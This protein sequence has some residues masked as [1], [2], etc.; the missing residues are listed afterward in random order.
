M[1]RTDKHTKNRL[2]RNI[3]VSLHSIA[4]QLIMLGVLW[5]ALPV[6]ADTALQAKSTDN[7]FKLGELQLASLNIFNDEV[8]PR[9]EP[10]NTQLEEK[11]NTGW[12]FYVDNDLFLNGDR[13]R[14]YTG[15][16]ALTLSGRRA[17]EYWYSLDR[18]LSNA[19]RLTGF[20]KL[21][22]SE[23]SVPLHSLE[24]GL[25]AF[26]PN[27]TSAQEPL[28]NDRPY[29]SLL[30]LSNTQQTVGFERGVA[31]QSTFTLGILGLPFVGELQQELH[32]VFD[33]DQ[34][35]GWKNQI[36]DGGELTFRY[37]VSRQQTISK[38]HKAN[39]KGYEVKTSYGGSVGFLTDAYV[40][41]SGRWGKINTPWWSFNPELTDYIKQDTPIAAD[42]SRVSLSRK[43]EFYFW[44]GVSLKLTIYNAFLQ[45]QFRD[46]PVDYSTGDLEHVVADA[47]LGVTKQFKNAIRMSY[48]VRGRSAEL[49]SGDAAREPAWAGFIF[50]RAY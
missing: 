1:N 47:W 30:F 45:G 2:A 28:A 50:S 19:D 41:L 43:S 10:L 5:V 46:N 35:Q 20:E 42:T 17:K 18:I 27:D 15:G 48:V 38:K 29:A 4:G 26:T 31:Y 33:Q 37:A 44:S 36:S 16:F 11:F 14:D 25:V 6:S 34:P 21:S 9:E 23:R 24:L 49:R 32:D 7:T 40:A 22:G 3:W 39:G 12:A 13:D 8:I